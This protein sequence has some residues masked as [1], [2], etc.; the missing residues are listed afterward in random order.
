[1]GQTE[2]GLQDEGVTFRVL[3]KGISGLSRASF[4]PRAYRDSP[5]LPWI[6]ENP[7]G[8]GWSCRIVKESI[9]PGEEVVSG[10][11]SYQVQR[12]R[13]HLTNVPDKEAGA[14]RAATQNRNVVSTMG[15]RF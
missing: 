2:K 14:N 9:L 13:G 4:F 8:P 3:S 11:R 7:R 5:G 6:E 15:S 12:S 1:M 10:S